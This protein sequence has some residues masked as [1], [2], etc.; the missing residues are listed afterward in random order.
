M[1]E[2]VKILYSQSAWLYRE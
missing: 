2:I 1:F